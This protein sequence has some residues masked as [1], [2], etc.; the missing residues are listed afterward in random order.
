MR[1]TNSTSCET[2]SEDYGESSRIKQIS[3]LAEASQ[4][5]GVEALFGEKSRNSNG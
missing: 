4:E 5:I 1:R 3:P 2:K